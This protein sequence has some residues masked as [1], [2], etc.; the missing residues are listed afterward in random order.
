MSKTRRSGRRSGEVMLEVLFFRTAAY[1]RLLRC[2]LA[3]S[4]VEYVLLNI[5]NSNL[6]MHYKIELK[7]FSD[8]RYMYFN[9]RYEQSL[10]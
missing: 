1:V 2:S 5:S 10:S 8:K 3:H 7:Y 6:Y 4:F 9:V